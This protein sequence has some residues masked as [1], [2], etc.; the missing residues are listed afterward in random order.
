MDYFL[1][2]NSIVNNFLG[3]RKIHLLGHNNLIHTPLSY[4]HFI[5]IL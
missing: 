2:N 4:S 5:E 3:V 1:V